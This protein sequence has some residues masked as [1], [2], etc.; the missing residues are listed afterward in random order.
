MANVKRI[1][2]YDV[3]D[4]VA[5]NQ[6]VYSTSAVKIGTYKGADLFRKVIPFV[7]PAGSTG[8]NVGLDAIPGAAII[9]IRGVAYTDNSGAV[10]PIPCSFPQSSSVYPPAAYISMYVSIANNDVRLRIGS[11]YSSNGF[12]GDLVVEY[13]L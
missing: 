10:V 7:V 6:G 1:N 5:R 8:Y 4:E 11:Q 3:K 13:T 12:Y 2:G 9:N